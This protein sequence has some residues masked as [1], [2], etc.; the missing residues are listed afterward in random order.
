LFINFM[1]PAFKDMPHPPV[2]TTVGDLSPTRRLG[3]FTWVALMCLLAWDFAGLDSAVMHQ[4]APGG[5]FVLRDN[6]WLENIL[7]TQAKQLALVIYV[8]LWIMLWWPRGLFRQLTRLQRTEIMTGITLSLITISTLKRFSLTSCPWD[9][10][11]F[12]GSAVYVS[13]WQWGMP[14]GG[15]G[16]CFPG[17]HVSSALAFI[18]LALPWLG[19]SQSAQRRI[20]QRMLI[21]VL[22]AGVVL[23]LTQTL[24][25]AHYPSH[26]FWTG[27]ICWMVA[28]ANHIAFGWWARRQSSASTSGN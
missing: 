10:Q 11:D 27:F 9:L 4:I 12:G 18:G 17:G 2:Y 5:I 25:G 8:G 21:G 16:H 26:T 7:H 19:S 6:W 20:G 22:L 28:L 15:S 14:D 13:H 1:Y 24:R 23:G 3:Q